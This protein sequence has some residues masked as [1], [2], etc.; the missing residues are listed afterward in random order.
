MEPEEL[1]I[2]HHPKGSELRGER[3]ADG[4]PGACRRSHGGYAAEEEQRECTPYTALGHCL[5]LAFPLR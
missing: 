3:A 5:Q 4:G 1:N 2:V